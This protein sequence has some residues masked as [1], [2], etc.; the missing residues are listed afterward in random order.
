MKIDHHNHLWMGAA[1]GEGFLDNPMSIEAILRDMDIAGLDMAG[2]CSVAQDMQNDYI[3]QAQRQHPDRLFG[4]AFVNAR[5]KQSPEILRRYL[6]E[7]L[8][9]L[10]LH[11]RLHGYPLSALGIVGPLMEVCQEFNVPVFV[12]GAGAEEFN[13]PYYFEEVARAFPEVSIIIGHMGAFNATDDAIKVA[14]RTPNI[15]LDTSLCDVL[16]VKT[17]LKALGPERLLMGSDWPGSDFRIELFKIKVATEDNPA[18]FEMV[19][20]ESYRK[21]VGMK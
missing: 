4:Y 8:Q 2:V 21:L 19:A 10:K 14:K 18:A 16:G 20:G 3:L 5:D 11:P 6:G 17:A 7:G 13:T 12:H 1:T 9:G 15:Y